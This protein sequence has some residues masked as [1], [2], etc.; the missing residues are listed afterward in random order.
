MLCHTT[1]VATLLRK[2][3]HVILPVD[4]V[5]VS[6]NW[7]ANEGVVRSWPKSLVRRS[8]D[9]SN[10][11]PS[12]RPPAHGGTKTT[13]NSSVVPQPGY[14]ECAPNPRPVQSASADTGIATNG[15]LP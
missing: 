13:P 1:G 6:I 4:V 15:G 7:W 11:M 14:A 10:A 2:R 3:T 5:A 9:V 12:E 8:R